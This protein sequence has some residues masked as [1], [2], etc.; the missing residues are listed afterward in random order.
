MFVLLF[1]GGCCNVK[2][3]PKLAIII[4]SLFPFVP[5]GFLFFLGDAIKC[6][7]RDR[8]LTNL[9]SSRP[10]QF[11]PLPPFPALFAL[12]ARS[13]RIFFFI[14]PLLFSSSIRLSLTNL[15]FL[16][17]HQ[18]LLFFFVFFLSCLNEIVLKTL[19]YP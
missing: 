19:C 2:L 4:P 10:F 12:T 5:S 7:C 11:R 8:S 14:G 1:N 15:L 17:S 16:R 3:L 6:R 13:S 9:L 18:P